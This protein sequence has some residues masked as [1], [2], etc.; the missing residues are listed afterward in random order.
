MPS[1]RPE[2]DRL[3]TSDALWCATFSLGQIRYVCRVTEMRRRRALRLRTLVSPK[4]T[5]GS[6][7]SVCTS[8]AILVLSASI[9][10]TDHRYLYIQFLKSTIPTLSHSPTFVPLSKKRSLVSGS[11]QICCL[12]TTLSLLSRASLSSCRS[13]LAHFFPFVCSSWAYY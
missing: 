5:S 10:S 4:P 7:Q 8:R 13:F 2:L 11:S 6:L 9:V 3:L 1:S 12:C